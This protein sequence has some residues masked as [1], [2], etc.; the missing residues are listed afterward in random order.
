M[1][2]TAACSVLHPKKKTYL[3]ELNRQR[4]WKLQ[5]LGLMTPAGIAPIAD[6]IGAPDDPFDIPDWIQERLMEEPVIWEYFQSF[7]QFYQR[8]KVGWIAEA[9]LRKEVAQQRL[10]YLLKMTRQGKMYGTQPLRRE[11]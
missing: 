5:Q 10:E 4:V 2:N 3:S 7:D 1:A 11:H 9:G 8:L 6:Q